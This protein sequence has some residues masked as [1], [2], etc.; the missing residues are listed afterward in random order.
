MFENMQDKIR[1][2]GKYLIYFPLSINIGLL[3]KGH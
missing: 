3:N 1:N 2:V